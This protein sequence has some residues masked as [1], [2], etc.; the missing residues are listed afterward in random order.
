MQ[1]QHIR[2]ERE[3]HLLS[4]TIDRPEVLNAVSAVTNFE[5]EVAF[6]AFE[7]DRQLWVAIITGAGSKAFCTGG[8]ISD[9]ASS[10]EGG[11]FRIPPTGFG[12]LT[13]RRCCYKPIIAAVNGMALGGGLEIALAADVI[14]ASERA[15]FGLPE[16]KIGGA[17]IAGGIHRLVR[18]IGLKPAMGM[19]LSAEPVSAVRAY[20]LGLVNLVVEPE[21]LMAA[22]RDFAD[23]IIRCAPLAIQAT[24]PCAIEGLNLGSVENAMRAQQE[25]DFEVLDQMIR[26]EDI[27]EGLN[28]F[29]E[30]RPPRWKN[31]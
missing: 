1:Y 27:R 31:R 6:D 14:I 17:A 4:I 9:M 7:Q 15:S 25:G 21:N 8:D 16:P 13:S 5:L 10:T 19:L 26:S 23:K 11:D 24:K 20:D 3:D 12:G 18:Q 30:K 2:V 28:A 29:L 22:A